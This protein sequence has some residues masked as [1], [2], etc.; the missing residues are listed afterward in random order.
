[1][2]TYEQER[3]SFIEEY[4]DLIDEYNTE[5]GT[6]LEDE[7]SDAFKN[8]QIKRPKISPSSF[9]REV[10]AVLR[11]MQGQ[12]DDLDIP[13]FVQNTLS[14]DGKNQSLLQPS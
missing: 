9:F 6:I 11:N 1:M 10:K 2:K 7:L 13:S 5:T 14:G 8:I 12:Y 3:N 4:G